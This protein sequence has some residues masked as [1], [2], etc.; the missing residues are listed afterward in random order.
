MGIITND[1]V[2]LI[3]TVMIDIFKTV[4]GWPAA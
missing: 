1:A 4:P 3:T 2:I